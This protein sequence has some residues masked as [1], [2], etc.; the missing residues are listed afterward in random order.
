MSQAVNIRVNC[1]ADSLRDVRQSLE[2]LDDVDQKTLQ[3]L[4]LVVNEL[5]GNAIKHSDLCDED[6]IEIA[7]T[8][9][10]EVLRIDV[11]DQG[12]GFTFPEENTVGRRGLPLVQSLTDH[13]GISRNEHTHAWAEIRGT[14]RAPETT[15]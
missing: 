14:S 5:V 3:T 10:G 12:S 15:S 7:V 11:R 1:R 4:K 6:E 13:F 9:Q 8:S 2:Q